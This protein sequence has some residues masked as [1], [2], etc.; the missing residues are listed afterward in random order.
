MHGVHESMHYLAFS[1]QHKGDGP[2]EG[3]GTGTDGVVAA[4]VQWP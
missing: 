3:G 2:V 4:V 1:Y